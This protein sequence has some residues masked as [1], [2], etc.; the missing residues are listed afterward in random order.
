MFGATGGG[1]NERGLAQLLCPLLLDLM[2]QQDV[3]MLTI[4]TS[5]HDYTTW[6][7]LRIGIYGIQL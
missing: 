2:T 7:D 6:G 5:T 4:N 1:H 3:D